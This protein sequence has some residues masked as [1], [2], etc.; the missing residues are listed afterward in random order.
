LVAFSLMA[1][2][3]WV[4]SGPRAARRDLRTPTGWGRFTRLVGEAPLVYLTRLRLNLAARWLRDTD[5]PIAAVAGQVGYGS[6]YSFLRAFTRHHG[7]PPG[8]Y[9]R[10]SRASS[11]ARQ[12][13]PTPATALTPPGDRPAAISGSDPVPR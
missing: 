2:N 6:E 5:D 1:V 7:Q 8:R 3:V 11:E 9:R 13:N 4:R 12:P 10:Q